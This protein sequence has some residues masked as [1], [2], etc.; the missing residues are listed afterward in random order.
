M[1]NTIEVYNFLKFSRDND[2]YHSELNLEEMLQTYFP[3]SIP[4][5]VQDMSD[6]TAAFYGTMLSKTQLFG[7][8]SAVDALATATI[9]EMGHFKARQAM[10]RYPKSGRCFCYCNNTYYG[11]KN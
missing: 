5:F 7:G 11:K 6:I 9:T 2:V 4:T 3:E 8:A 1:S 10:E